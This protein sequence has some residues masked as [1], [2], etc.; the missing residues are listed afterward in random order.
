MDVV[1]VVTIITRGHARTMNQF[2]WEGVEEGTARP[3]V[4]LGWVWHTKRAR[5]SHIKR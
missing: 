5:V 1:Y 4:N 2:F 3:Q